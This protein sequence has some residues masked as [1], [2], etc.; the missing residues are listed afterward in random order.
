MRD[1]HS[2]H[3]A[4]FAMRRE[5]HV[6]S[7]DHQVRPL[8]PELERG[9]AN[10]SA[11]QEPCLAK[12]LEAVADAPHQSAAIGELAD[13]LH[14]RRESRDGARAQVIAV[15]EPA[16]QDHAVAPF[17]IR[18]LVPQVLELGA[19]DL[20][21]DPTTVPVRPRPRKNHDPELHRRGLSSEWSSKR[22]SSITWLARSRSHI[23]STRWRASRSSAASRVTSMYLPTRTSSTSRNPSDARPCLTVMPWGSFTT[24]FGVTIT[25]AVVFIV[26]SRSWLWA[27]TAVCRPVC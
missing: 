17:Q 21:D 3:V 13:L 23:S 2:D 6:V 20:V 24:G 11:W 10:Q 9:V 27:E 15:R 16:R 12:D 4:L 18:V 7:L 14:H 22:K 5:R 26:M 8:A 19:H 1:R 25:R